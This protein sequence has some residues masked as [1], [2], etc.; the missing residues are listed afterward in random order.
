MN[1]G[2]LGYS[3]F[4]TVLGMSVVFLF[5]AGLSFLMLLL[6]AVFRDT[7]GSNPVASRPGGRAPADRSRFGGRARPGARS[8]AGAGSRASATASATEPAEKI[9]HWVFAAVAAYLCSEDISAQ[10]W[11]AAKTD[12][13]QGWRMGGRFLNRGTGV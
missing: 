13:H 7:V 11:R 2:L 3:I 4:A 8:K 10:S 9:P 5:L 12:Q 1:H 6:K